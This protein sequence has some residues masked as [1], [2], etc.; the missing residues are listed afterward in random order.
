MNMDVCIFIAINI[1][2]LKTTI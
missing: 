2:S 1:V